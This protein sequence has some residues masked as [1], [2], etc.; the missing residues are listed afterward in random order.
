MNTTMA[1]FDDPR[2][3]QAV[4]LAMNRDAML[5]LW[6]AGKVLSQ[7]I[8]PPGLPGFSSG[9]KVYDRDVAAARRLLAAAGYGPS[10]PL[11]ALRLC[12]S[13]GTESSR[14]IDTVMV[15]SLADAGIQVDLQYV[16]WSDLDSLAGC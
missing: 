15:N 3:R 7:G 8:L 10:N 14:Q 12:K 11:P 13:G 16:R 6:P 4:A 2:V 5:N 1:P 9:Q